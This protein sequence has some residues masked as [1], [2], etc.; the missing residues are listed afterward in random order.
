MRGGGVFP[1]LFIVWFLDVRVIHS[2]IP[3]TMSLTVFRE[4]RRL[5]QISTLITDRYLDRVVANVDILPPNAIVSLGPMKIRALMF[6]R[7]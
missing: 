4:Q 6:Y 7:I 3:R 5:A 2:L 1:L